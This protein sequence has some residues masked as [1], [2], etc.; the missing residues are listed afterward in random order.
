MGEL[1]QLFNLILSSIT[2]ILVVFMMFCII[3]VYRT[4]Q[5]WKPVINNTISIMNRGSGGTGANV[6]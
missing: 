4:I 6:K 1:T 3:F 2:T 5:M